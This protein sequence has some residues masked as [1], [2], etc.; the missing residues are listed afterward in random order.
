MSTIAR[1]K[2]VWDLFQYKIGF[3]KP[4]YC[5]FI[6]TEECNSRCSFCNVWKTSNPKTIELETIKQ[7]F[8]SS[9]LDGLRWF[10]LTG[11]EPFLHGQLVEIVKYLSYRFG[12][13]KIWIPTN[14]LATETIIRQ[15]KQMLEYNIGIT[16]SV[17]GKPQT[18]NKLRGGDFYK[19]TIKTIKELS[20]LPVDLSIG[21][22]ITPKNWD[23]IQ[24]VYSLAKD[25]DV[26]FSC[27]PMLVSHI[28]YKNENIKPIFSK[29]ML[30]HLNL[31]FEK[32]GMTA[33]YRGIIEYLRKPQ[34]LVVPC[35]ALRNSFHLAVDATVYP[36]LY[37]NRPVGNLKRMN[38]EK[39]WNS[40]KATQIRREI[41][42]GKC[43][44][45]WVEC[46]SYRNIRYARPLWSY[47][48]RVIK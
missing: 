31:F 6:I 44:N 26:N 47:L 18:H 39:L 17:D 41:A 21:F 27:R 38:M 25:F 19:Q 42:E 8:S 7:V 35:T 24:Y 43:P 48:A 5:N 16:V 13:P 23:E 1:F 29:E 9:F 34:Q 33:Y 22:T 4:R 45:C 30:E 37:Y 14:G 12:N 10:Q 11:G 2:T 46:E 40:T 20:K 3:N 32:I 15:T 28:Y 36:C